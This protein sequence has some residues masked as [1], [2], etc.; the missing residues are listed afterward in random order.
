MQTKR[1]IPENT[2]GLKEGAE[3]ITADGHKIGSVERVFA[4]EGSHKATHLLVASGMLFK[5]HTPIPVTWIDTVTDDSITLA[6][7]EKLL[8]GLP[9]YKS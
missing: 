3:V 8:K 2:V 7:S 4:D 9:E 6:V 1:N 5:T